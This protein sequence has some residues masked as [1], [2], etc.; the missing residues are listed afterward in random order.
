MIRLCSICARGG[1][2]GVPG[3]NIRLLEGKPLIAHTVEQ[4]LQSGQFEAITVSSDSDD[5]LKAASDAG[6]HVLIK[7][8]DEL[9]S[10]TAA[11]IP[12]IRHCIQSTENQLGIKA[13]QIIDLDATAPLRHIEDILAVIDMMGDPD[14]SNVITAMPARRSPYFNMVECGSDGV[15]KLSKTLSTQVVRRQ[16]APDCYDMNASIYG[17]QREMLFTSDTLFH[18]G[19]RLHVMPEER[20]IDIDTEIDFVLVSALMRQAAMKD[21]VNA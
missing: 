10:D 7:R 19:T 4:A 3:K 2:K 13:E 15:P 11:K 5:I 16:D 21:Q 20:S 17:W 12:V 18:E 1:S 14:V 8:P 6:A 9:A